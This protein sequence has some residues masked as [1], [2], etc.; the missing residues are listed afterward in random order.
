MC[1]R[2]V[3]ETVWSKVI[4]KKKKRNKRISLTGMGRDGVW[5][6][7]EINSCI[8]INICHHARGKTAQLFPLLWAPDT[9][10]CLS[11]GSLAHIWPKQYVRVK[12]W[13]AETVC[14][15]RFLCIYNVPDENMDL[16]TC[17]N[18]IYN[19]YS[20]SEFWTNTL[21]SSAMLLLSL[22]R[23]NKL[24]YCTETALLPLLSS[25]AHKEYSGFML[26]L[27]CPN[28]PHK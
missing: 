23:T 11:E 14:I 18:V 8:N 28:M 17:S 20:P 21:S 25:T 2:T 16:L 3:W 26:S 7:R 15:S 19:I 24:N 27:V 1:D 9:C 5:C 4:L 13:Q 6:H 12:G 22:D 10:L